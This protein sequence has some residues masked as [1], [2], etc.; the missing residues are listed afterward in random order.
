M[1]RRSLLNVTSQKK[2][3]TM[4]PTMQ[5]EPNPE[6]ATYITGSGLSLTISADPAQGRIAAG[7]WCA[8]ARDNRT[9]PDTVGNKYDS[10]TRTASSCFMRGLSE[11]YTI[12]K[13]DGSNF[14]WRR[15]VFTMKG[16]RL[17][18]PT[19]GSLSD[20][21]LYLISTNVGYS[22]HTT[23]VNGPDITDAEYWNR[24]TG[25]IFKGEGGT[26]WLFVE[27]AKLDN[28]RIT[29]LY[30]R[31]IRLGGGS[32]D[33]YMSKKKFWH[34]FNRNL[35]YNDDERGGGKA[36]SAYSTEGKP[37]MGNIYVLDILIASGNVPEGS[38]CS[39]T[40]ESC[41]YWHER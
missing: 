11:K 13:D 26:D 18:E 8:S 29:P 14:L 27:N 9:S 38:V 17:H 22:R 7:L 21:D 36:P 16:R 2:S 24:L 20:I 28:S 32:S 37:G 1:T 12:T 5:T 19:T 41:L 30:D 25:I 4:L 39:L 6:Q 33:A 40:P 3:D 23:V 15:I 34:P 35:V 10:S 31:T